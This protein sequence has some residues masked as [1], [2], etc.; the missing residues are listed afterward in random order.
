MDDL[1]HVV[2]L[3]RVVRDDGVESVFLTVDRVVALDAW[4]LFEVVLWQIRDELADELQAF[5]LC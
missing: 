1:L 4:S 5:F 3:V 2:W